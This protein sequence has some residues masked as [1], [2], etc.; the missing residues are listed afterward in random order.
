MSYKRIENIVG[1]EENSGYQ[2][3]L[4]FPQCFQKPFSSVLLELGIVWK[5]SHD[6]FTL[7][8]L[9]PSVTHPPSLY[10]LLPVTAMQSEHLKSIF[11][12]SGKS[13]WAIFYMKKELHAFSKSINGLLSVL[14]SPHELIRGGSFCYLWIFYWPQV[15]SL[16]W[17]IGCMLFNAILMLYLTCQFWAL[18][19]QQQIK[20][21]CQK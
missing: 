10:N 8:L 5:A 14:S 12:L 1:K 21:W 13:K 20:I 18:P 16:L 9:V 19:I 17:L 15:Y 4:L 11:I 7:I 3:F 2:H 6:R